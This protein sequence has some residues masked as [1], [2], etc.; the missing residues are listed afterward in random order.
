MFMGV[1]YTQLFEIRLY[2]HEF[3]TVGSYNRV[4]IESYFYIQMSKEVTF[5]NG[6]YVVPCKSMY[7]S[8]CIFKTVYRV[9][10][11]NS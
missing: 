5:I 9:G 3:V 10:S 2:K 11:L 8:D 7:S 6:C 4:K 1:Y